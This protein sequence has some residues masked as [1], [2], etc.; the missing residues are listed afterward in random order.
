[1]RGRLNVVI[2]GHVDEEKI[3]ERGGIRS[4]REGEERC[5]LSVDFEHVETTVMPD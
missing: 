5:F 2:S 4:E 1:M 3:G